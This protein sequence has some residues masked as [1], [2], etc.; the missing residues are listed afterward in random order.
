MKKLVIAILLC[1]AGACIARPTQDSQISKEKIGNVLSC[2]LT[3]LPSYPDSPVRF[4]S[5]SYLVRYY[6]GILTPD[7][8]EP[9][10]LQL[11]VYGP[12]EESATLYQVYF[13][14]QNEQESIN[15]GQWG[16]LV[17]KD[18]HL[19]L[20]DTPGGLATHAE[21]EKLVK[22][23]S[24]RPSLSLSEKDVQPGADSCVYQQ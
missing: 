19:E 6:Y 7:A 23:I 17:K 1:S 10:E 16:S 4:D 21:W 24:K 14:K 15:I 9:D 20:G 12:K 8:E 13:E 3:K 22:V 2:L 18:G 11:I 5:H